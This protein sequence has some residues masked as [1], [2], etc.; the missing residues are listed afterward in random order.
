M[1]YIYMI[2]V[3]SDFHTLCS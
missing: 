3:H 1:I 2:N